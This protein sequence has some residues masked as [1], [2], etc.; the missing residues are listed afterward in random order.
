[1][2]DRRRGRSTKVECA[3]SGRAWPLKGK[4]PR[5]NAPL[6]QAN[7]A[8]NAG[9]PGA[10]QPAQHLKRVVHPPPRVDLALVGLRLAA[11]P[12]H[13]KDRRRPEQV[14]VRSRYSRTNTWAGC[15]LCSG[16]ADRRPRRAIRRRRRG[17]CRRSRRRFSLGMGWIDVPRLACRGVACSAVP[18]LHWR[19]IGIPTVSTSKHF[20]LPALPDFVAEPVVGV[21]GDDEV[22]DLPAVAAAAPLLI[23]LRFRRDCRS[24]PHRGITRIPQFVILFGPTAWAELCAAKHDCRGGRDHAQCSC[25]R[26]P[27]A[28][29]RI[30]RNRYRGM[31][32]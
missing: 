20:P 29:L 11:A 19:P 6:L 17:T 15:L 30:E 26:V 22:P 18:L 7:D 21:G 13:P 28:H 4:R 14:E 25:D 5:A 8:P 2:S 12:W 3:L 9:A 32:C 27:V 1:M 31:R 24:G 23:A 10:G 16:T